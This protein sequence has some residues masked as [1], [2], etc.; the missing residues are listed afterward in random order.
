MKN[1]EFLQ[2]ILTSSNLGGADTYNQS[3]KSSSSQELCFHNV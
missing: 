2:N 3:D 1:V